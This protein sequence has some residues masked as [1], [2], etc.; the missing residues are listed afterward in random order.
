LAQ[1]GF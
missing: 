1:L